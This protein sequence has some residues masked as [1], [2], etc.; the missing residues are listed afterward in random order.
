M[1]IGRVLVAV[2]VAM[3]LTS[4]STAATTS[5]DDYSPAVMRMDYAVGDLTAHVHA[6]RTLVGV[7]PLV[8]GFHDDL[9]RE[10]ARQGFVVVVVDDRWSVAAHEELWRELNAG[11]GPLAERFA[12]FVGNVAV[13]EP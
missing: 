9:A 10:S 2:A 8:F 3:M 11:G 1:A 6:P 12:G 5:G 4:P 7:R 13:A